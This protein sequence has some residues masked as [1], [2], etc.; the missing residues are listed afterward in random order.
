[1]T[2][3]GPTDAYARRVE[4][5]TDPSDPRLAGFDVRR[6]RA[7]RRTGRFLC[8]GPLV[9]AALLDGPHD[10]EAVLAAERK[11]GDFADLDAPTFVAADDVIRRAVGFDFHRGVIALG[12][13]VPTPLPDDAGG[14]TLALDGVEDAENVGSLLRLAAGFGCRG[15]LLGPG[16][17]DP[18]YRRVV[19]VSM[20]HALRLPLQEVDDLAAAVVAFSGRSIAATLAADAVPLRTLE[21]NASTLLVV[22]SE[23][24]GVSPAVA[25]VCDVRTTIPMSAGTDSLNVAV[26]AGIVLHHLKGL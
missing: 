16:T 20:G 5:V 13:R 12:R 19:R 14:T 26:A 2:A 1:M 3:A 17:H 9:V 25:A 8:E 4:R 22:G 10:V 6:D 18:L 7:L 23:H 21:P 11:A 15:V 24:R